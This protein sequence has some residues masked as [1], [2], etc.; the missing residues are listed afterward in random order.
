MFKWKLHYLLDQFHSYTNDLAFY[1]KGIAF[2]DQ[3]VDVNVHVRRWARQ[4]TN[5]KLA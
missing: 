4:S 1:W 5:P 3:V 2:S